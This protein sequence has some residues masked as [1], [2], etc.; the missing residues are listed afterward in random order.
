MLL[1]KNGEIHTGTGEVFLGQDILIDGKNI[2]EIGKDLKKDGAEII[3]ASGKVVFPGFID[4][5][6][7]LGTE[8]S[9]LRG[10]RD[11]EEMTGILTP[12]MNVKYAITPSHVNDANWASYGI[13]TANITAGDMNIIGGQ[14]AIIKTFG[15]SLEE[16]LVKEYS[17]LKGS[18]SQN[19]KRVYAGRGMLGTTMKMYGILKDTLDDAKRYIV[20]RNEGEAPVNETL[21]IYAKVLNKEV[22]LFITAERKVE[23]EAVFDIMKEFD[24]NLVITHACA[25]DLCEES[26]KEYGASVIFGDQLYMSMDVFK[27][28]MREIAKMNKS[29]VTVALARASSMP[30]GAQS[31]LWNALNIR[32]FGVESED[33]LRMTTV[34]PA[35]ILGIFDRVGSIEVGKEA[36]ITI[37]SENP[38]DTYKAN[39]EKTLIGGRLVYCREANNKC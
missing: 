36:D 38:F 25:A 4:S 23:I 31:F 3:D 28:N 30:G 6:G 8:D 27:G 29:G 39:A 7:R 19:V 9:S 18:V 15:K 35:K 5:L 16:L 11:N 2:I 37:W 21:E 22:P 13:T 12:G 1:I 33:V 17:G 14:M 26:I 24:I 34:N 32:G 10:S 20:S